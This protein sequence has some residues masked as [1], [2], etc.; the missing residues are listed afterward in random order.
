MIMLQRIGNYG[1][2]KA[3]LENPKHFNIEGF[4]EYYSEQERQL[5]NKMQEKL[6]GKQSR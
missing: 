2:L 4:E 5:L 6:R 3:L 1:V